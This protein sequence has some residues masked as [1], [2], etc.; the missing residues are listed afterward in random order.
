[1]AGAVQAQN[2]AAASGAGAVLR[3]LDKVNGRV[4]DVEVPVGGS[5]KTQGLMVTVSDCRYPVDNPT[6]EAY[7]Y[8]RIRNP[9]DGVDFFQGWMIASSPAL[10]ALDHNRYDVWVLRCKIS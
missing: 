3:S 1:M 6:G 7:A 2:V 8:L 5:A 10:S 9:Q 4:E